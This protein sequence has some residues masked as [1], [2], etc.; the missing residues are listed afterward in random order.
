MYKLQI[1][2]KR[3]ID[4]ILSFIVGICVFPLLIIIPI[5]I[6]TGSQ[7]PILFIQN[8]V[9]RNKNVFKLIKFRTMHLSVTPPPREW[10]KEEESRI[11]PFGR[12]LRDMGLDELP[13]LFNIIK[14][15]MSIIGPRP[16][17]TEDV[18][19]IPHQFQNIFNMKPGV[20]SLAVIEG[21]H[22]I[23]MEKRIE[24]HSKYVSE[25]SLSLDIRILWKSLFVVLKRENAAD[26]LVNTIN[27]SNT[28]NNKI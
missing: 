18:E 22:A 15:E 11:I 12:Y 17:L 2:I 13:Q 8:R 19:E 23:P 7:G 26:T 1:I 6:K 16:L 28:D 4:I 5:I 21:R 27:Q 9:G 24:L 3:C 10:N 20:L 14:G 25:W